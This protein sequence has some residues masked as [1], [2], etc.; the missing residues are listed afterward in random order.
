MTALQYSSIPQMAFTYVARSPADQPIVC[1][2]V[3]RWPSG[4]TRVVLG[5]YGTA[6]VM[7]MDGPEPGGAVA[8]ARDAYSHASDGW[9]SAEYRQEMAAVLTQR[10]LDSLATQSAEQR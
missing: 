1:V 7:V 10:C 9:A 3:A 2:A 5:G 6:P 4:R 8:A